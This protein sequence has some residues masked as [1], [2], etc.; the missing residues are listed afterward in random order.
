METDTFLIRV[1]PR[2]PSNWRKNKKTS[3]ALCPAGHVRVACLPAG[4]MLKDFLL[5]FFF[6]P[7]SASSLFSFFTGRYSPWLKEFNFHLLR[8]D[9]QFQ[10]QAALWW[11]LKREAVECRER[12]PRAHCRRVCRADV[13]RLSIHLLPQPIAAGPA[14]EFDFDCYAGH[15]QPTLTL[16]RSGNRGTWSGICS[17]KDIGQAPLP[18]PHARPR[19]L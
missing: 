4:H 3:S 5:S 15:S 10:T 14:F 17:W 8:G 19:R 7:P 16:Q 1:S 18:C 9:I 11:A 13:R 12:K 6:L 2:G